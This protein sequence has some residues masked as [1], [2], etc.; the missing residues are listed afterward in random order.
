MRLEHLGALGIM[1]GTAPLMWIESVLGHSFLT[2]NLLS[3][4]SLIETSD[5]ELSGIH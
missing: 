1:G 4:C 3:P 5:T 2:C